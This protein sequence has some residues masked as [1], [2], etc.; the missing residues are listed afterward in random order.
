MFTNSNY[1][2]RETTLEKEGVKGSKL[3]VT[4][5]YSTLQCLD[6]SSRTDEKEFNEKMTIEYNH[7][8]SKV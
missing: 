7:D 2:C 4:L 5:E 1:A 8:D 3:E 6:V